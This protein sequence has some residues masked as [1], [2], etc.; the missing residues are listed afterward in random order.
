MR[1]RISQ[2]MAGMLAAAL[3]I[4]L[5]AAVACGAASA[6]G[7]KQG[8]GQGPI[9]PSTYDPQLSI[10][11]LVDKVA[12]A[13][14]NI[15]TASRMRVPGMFGSDNL[16][17]WFFGP[18]APGMPFQMPRDREVERRSV[19]SGFIVD[20][21]GLV[22]TN[23]HVVD[24][25]DEVEVQLSD[26]RTFEAELLGSDERT[27]VALLQLREAQGLPAAEWGDSDGLAV[28][29]WV[30]AIGNPF[31]LD[32]TVTSGIVSAKERVIGAGRYDDFIQTD[33]SINPGNS[34]GPLFNLR[35]QVVG[36]N[37]A[38]APRGQGIGF[39]IPSNLALG[40]IE[41]LRGSGR[42]VR[43][44]LGIGFQAL[45]DDLAQAFGLANKHGAVV[46]HVGDGSPA[47]KGGMKAGDVIVEV[48]GKKLLSAR[49]LPAVVAALE[50]GSKAKFV[51]VRNGKRRTLRIV[52]GEMPDDADRPAAGPAKPDDAPD[53]AATA[54][55]FSVRPLDD[56]LRRRLGAGE[57][58]RGVVVD[59]VVPGTAASR[60][61][62]KGDIVVEVNRDP[63]GSVEQLEKLTSVLK[64]GDDLLLLVF[65][66]GSWRYVVIRL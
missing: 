58:E 15:K 64:A 51:V 17:E 36:I 54:L 29:D 47:G 61:L 57:V 30:V 33:A 37:T 21:A 6:K 63:V 35:G 62:D 56:Q 40:V 48:D 20:P 53:S 26:D 55:G 25:A 12:P 41:E 49:Q 45:D 28:G 59:R 19:G 9:E 50:P 38:I 1:Y 3:G 39:A 43:G 27:D 34:G 23:Y 4:A 65:R 24:G 2:R 11:P 32:H 7:E 60:A 44:W 46:A 52:V 16:F 13:V 10:A 8:G 31:G 42:V 18:R 22:V 66:K 5:I 14:V